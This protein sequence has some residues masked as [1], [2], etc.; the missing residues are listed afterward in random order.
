M[1]KKEILIEPG[2][3][4]LIRVGLGGPEGNYGTGESKPHF[5][6]LQ[7]DPKKIILFGINHT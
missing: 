5:G 6:I 3:S 7:E 4:Y 1:E 2:N